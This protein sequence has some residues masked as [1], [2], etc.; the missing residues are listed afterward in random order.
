MPGRLR[1]VGA[2]RAQNLVESRRMRE[3]T[4][5]GSKSLSRF[6]EVHL[7]VTCPA[8]S[9]RSFLE[10]G[11]LRFQL[12]R[13]DLRTKVSLRVWVDDRSPEVYSRF[14][15]A[16]GFGGQKRAGNDVRFGAARAYALWRRTLK[17]A[18]V[19]VSRGWTG[20]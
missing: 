2:M 1:F 18:S 3:A 17:T 12:R 16:A 19:Q 11:R 9:R 8:F 20:A 7:I 15:T 13:S 10:D 14:A 4:P 5:T 6:L